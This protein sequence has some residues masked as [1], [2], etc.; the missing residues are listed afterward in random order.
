M[1]VVAILA[2]VI[3]SSPL[4]IKPLFKSTAVV[5]PYNLSIYSH[6]SSTEQMLEF[7]NS[8]DIKFGVIKRFNLLKHYNIDTVAEKNW[9]NIL[10]EKYDKNV[11]VGSTEY[12]AVDV[13][14]YD[15][16]PDTAYKIVNGVLD[17]LNQKV[18]GVQK[19]KSIEVAMIWKKQMDYKK[20]ECDSLQN[21]S[22]SLSTEYGLLDYGNQ[23]REVTRA[24]YQSSKNS[25]VSTAMKNMEE[26]GMELNAVNQHLNAALANYDELL[27]KYEDAMKDVNKQLTYS[28]MVT[29]PYVSDKKAYPVRWLIVLISCGAAF[30][31]SA[32]F[33]RIL[34]KL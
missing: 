18:L 32:L 30:L 9:K 26:K 17:V 13:T 29:S 21:L 3:F 5:Y 14:V 10:L 6:E 2:S 1:Q 15:V 24:Y 31:F 12:E 19:E 33:L 4:F 25:D 7:L 20:K 22:K 16:S 11:T 34:E 27:I 23:T 28:S 8:S